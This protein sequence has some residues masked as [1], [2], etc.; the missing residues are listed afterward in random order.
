M[1]VCVCAPDGN[2]P[3]GERERERERALLALDICLVSR[4]KDVLVNF[5]VCVEGSLLCG[6]GGRSREI[7][8]RNERER[9]RERSGFMR[10]YGTV[11]TT[12]LLY[13]V[14]CLIPCMYNGHFEANIPL[15]AITMSQAN[16]CSELCSAGSNQSK[17]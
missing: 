11:S 12:P 14:V 13:I 4:A 6:G 9:E 10:E 1:H 8:I 3:T 15:P 7:E 16:A 2:F 5:C 17:V